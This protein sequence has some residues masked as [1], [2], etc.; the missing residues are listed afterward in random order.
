MTSYSAIKQAATQHP[1]VAPAPAPVPSVRLYVEREDR[2]DSWFV[3]VGHVTE[4][5]RWKTE[6][7]VHPSYGQ[8]IFV[9]HGRGVMNREGAQ[10]PFEAPCALLLP[11][12]CVHGLD[13]E[14]D[15]DRW[16]VTIELSYLAQTNTRLPEFVQLW[17]QPRVIPLSY[18]EDGPTEF[19]DL[20]RRMEQE[21][22][23][24]MVGHAVG[25]EALLVSLMLMLVR[26][27]RL[28]EINKDGAT[29]H[30]IRLA[31]RFR[32]LINQHYRQN[33]KLPDYAALMAVSATQLRS[34]CL[35]A[36]GL[37]PIKLIHARLIIEAK[38][39]LI[40]SERS[41]EQIAYDLGFS[42]TAYFTRFF[43]KEVGQS[44]SQF[45]VSSQA[46]AGKA[47]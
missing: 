43:R 13:Y 17:S 37:S 31:E 4:R 38:R 28:D 30:A 24:K 20:I 23:S 29:R 45:R 35:A 10:V 8:V 3:H 46:G 32:M 36:T 44:P 33:L 22:R 26:G 40:F 1:A 42:D 25:T 41:I 18:S 7:H 34:A 12:E 47:A 19:Y 11:P 5:G 6:P 27:T 14:L 39:N 21:T 2:D 9:R 16:V 15:A